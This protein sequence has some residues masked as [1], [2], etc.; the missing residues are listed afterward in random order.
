MRARGDGLR[1]L[2]PRESLPRTPHYQGQDPELR[3]RQV[4]GL[5]VP[6]HGVATRVELQRT[7]PEDTVPVLAF[8]PPEPPQDGLDPRL[9]L[10]GVEGLGYVVVRPEIGRASCRERV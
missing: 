9:E 1:D 6:S 4:Q 7:Q 3:R 2:G 8:L 10:L 5:P